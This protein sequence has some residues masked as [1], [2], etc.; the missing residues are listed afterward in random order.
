MRHKQWGILVLVLALLALAGCAKQEAGKALSF[1]F[2]PGET[3]KYHTTM[4][5]KSTMMGQS[6]PMKMDLEQTNTVQE[7]LPTG[8][9]RIEQRFDKVGMTSDGPMGALLGTVAKQMEGKSFQIVTSPAGKVESVSGLNEL[10]GMSQSGMDVDQMASQFYSPLPE[11]PVKPGES[12]SQDK[13]IP[14]ASGGASLS[15]HIT[16]KYTLLGY[17][18]KGGATCAKIKTSG[19]FEITGTAGPQGSMSGK[20]TVEGLWYLDPE[21]GRMVEVS[22]KSNTA[23]TVTPPKGMAMTI[24]MEQDIKVELVK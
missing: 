9:V 5:M 16:T 10:G 12:W 1:K 11:N 17:E 7:V 23:M 24:T 21:A 8:S 13:T 4:D 14:I 20:G 19:T 22:A 18:P 15:N 2:K 6:F 3:L